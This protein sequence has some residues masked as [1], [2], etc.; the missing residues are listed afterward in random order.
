MQHKDNRN[1]RKDRESMDKTYSRIMTIEELCEF[2]VIGR[3]AAYRLLSSGIIKGF[4]VGRIWKIP[5]ENVNEYISTHSG[6][7]S[8]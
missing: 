6:I 5:R 1:Q 3:N 7:V 2:L 4:R 8:N